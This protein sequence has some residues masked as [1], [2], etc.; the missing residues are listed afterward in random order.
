M[1]VFKEDLISLLI[2]Y[3]FD[4]YSIFY[5]ISNRIES[6]L[7]GGEVHALHSEL[8]GLNNLLSLTTNR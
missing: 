4:D 2:K 1:P 3:R 5:E 8:K 6:K 7:D